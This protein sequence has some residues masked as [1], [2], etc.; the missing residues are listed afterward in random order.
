MTDFWIQES[1][2]LSS[3]CSQPRTLT[4]HV[5]THH[6]PTLHTKLTILHVQDGQG[7]RRIYFKGGSRGRGRKCRLAEQGESG[8]RETAAQ[9][10]DGP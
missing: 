9:G 1:T 4:N 6:S 3:F 5:H 2:F 10:P 8:A 7:G